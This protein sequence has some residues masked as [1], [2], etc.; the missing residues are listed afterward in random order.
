M[1]ISFPLDLPK[2]RFNPSA[3][4]PSSNLLGIGMKI[5]LITFLSKN[6]FGFKVTFEVCSD[7]SRMFHPRIFLGV[8]I[9]LLT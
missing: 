6:L 3:L 4:L 5:Y 7:S 2:M 9:L 1:N 8:N